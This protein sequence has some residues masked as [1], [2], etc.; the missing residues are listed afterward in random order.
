MENI[1]EKTLRDL[2][3]AEYAEKLKAFK[4]LEKE[5]KQLDEAFRKDLTEGMK[6]LNVVEIKVDDVKFRYVD[7]T[8]KEDFDKAKLKLENPE[9]YAKYV[10]T[11]PVSA[12]IRTSIV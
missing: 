10:T 11:K 4:K 3:P 12:Y 8:T 2:V 7:E 1:K 5:L 6:E 9:V